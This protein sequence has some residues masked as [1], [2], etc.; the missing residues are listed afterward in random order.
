M[1][2]HT[3]IPARILTSTRE[4]HHKRLWLAVSRRGTLKQHF[5]RLYNNSL[6]PIPSLGKIEGLSKKRILIQNCINAVVD[7]LGAGVTR[8]GTYLTVS[9]ILEEK[10]P[11]S[12]LLPVTT[13]F[14]F[15]FLRTR[16]SHNTQARSAR[17]CGI[18]SSA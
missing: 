9:V 18:C 17:V 14:R 15:S 3:V 6:V 4:S 16:Q 7:A 12:S 5:R 8:L 1:L 11:L 2:Y 10:V 13:H